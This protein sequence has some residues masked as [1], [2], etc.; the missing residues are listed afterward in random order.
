MTP[1]ASGLP[2][3]VDD[4]LTD[5]G[6][7]EDAELRAA[8]FTLG[9]LASLPAPAPSAEL[10][11]LMAGPGKDLPPGAPADELAR[12]RRRRIHRPTV[13]GLALVAGMATGV[14]GVAASS[15]A[16]VQAVSSSLQELL[17]DWRPSWSI[18]VPGAREFPRPEASGVDPGAAAADSGTDGSTVPAE[19]SGGH[20]AGP[21]P[22]PRQIPPTPAPDQQ[23]QQ[24]TG[25]VSSGGRQNNPQAPARGR[26]PSG[27]PGADLTGAGQSRADSFPGE[28]KLVGEGSLTEEALKPLADVLQSVNGAPATPGRPAPGDSWLQKSSR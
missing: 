7:P 14:G 8:L 26:G 2:A 11:R 5:A 13:L 23:A 21:Q 28:E 4:M 18:A 24:G 12:R 22:A 20:P 3:L 15:P 9:S 27:G 16:P 17:E 6:H 1:H 25:K 19:G 10:A